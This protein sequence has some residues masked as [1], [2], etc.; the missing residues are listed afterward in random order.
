MV[1]SNEIDTLQRI[2]MRQARDYSDYIISRLNDKIAAI[3]LFGSLAKQN[4]T[5][6]SDIDILIIHFGDREFEKRLA[7]ETFN[8]M[9]ETGAPI[10]YL[11]Y[12]YFQVK[13][14]PTYFV[15]YNLENGVVLYMK[16]Q[17]E[18]KKKEI[19]GYI[20]LSNIFEESAKYC[21]NQRFIRAAID[22]GY[23]SIELKIKALL[24]KRLNDL[25]G[26]HGGLV[27]KF[28]QYYVRTKKISKEI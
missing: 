3:I 27:S 14:N 9:M 16:N 22:L 28:G 25:P 6:N 12:G 7:A 11:A 2:M 18:L 8:F 19:E 5:Q 23:N 10:E 17:D 26:T 4:I 24:L 21:F 1:T 20:N 13:N 15:K